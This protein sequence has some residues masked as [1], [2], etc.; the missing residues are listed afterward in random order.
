MAVLKNRAAICSGTDGVTFG[1]RNQLST[2]A[3]YVRSQGQRAGAQVECR[4]R[5]ISQSHIAVVD[6]IIN[7]KPSGTRIQSL[8]DRQ[9][10]SDWIRG[11]SAETQVRI[12]LASGPRRRTKE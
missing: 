5:R 4:S 8:G 11:A 6:Q 3:N 2:K 10:S 12:E 1:P 9:E 7:I